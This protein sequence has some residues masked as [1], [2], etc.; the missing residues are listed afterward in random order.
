MNELDECDASTIHL[1]AAQRYVLLDKMDGSFVSPYTTGGSFRFGTKTGVNNKQA[2]EVQQF[3]ASSGRLRP[4]LPWFSSLDEGE[5][6]L[7]ALFFG[8]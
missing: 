2:K 4:S 5:L 3:A 7:T 6:Y 8:V 1:D